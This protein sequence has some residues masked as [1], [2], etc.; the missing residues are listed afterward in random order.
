MIAFIFVIVEIIH[1]LVLMTVYT[2]YGV[3]CFCRQMR[4]ARSREDRRLLIRST[5]FD[6]IVATILV[7]IVSV[8]PGYWKIIPFLSW[9]AIGAFVEKRRRQRR[10]MRLAE[11]EKNH[12]YVDSRELN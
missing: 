2:V 1:G 8:V 3:F 7:I 4:N 5:A 9:L 10:K 6:F 12:P 11:E